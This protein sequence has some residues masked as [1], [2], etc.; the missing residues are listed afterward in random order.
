MNG[1]DPNPVALHLCVMDTQLFERPS[2]HCSRMVD[3]RFVPEFGWQDGSEM[4]RARVRTSARM[5]N[6]V[7]L[8]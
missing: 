7:D 8:L 1:D 4:K 2:S 5:T 6:A 3:A